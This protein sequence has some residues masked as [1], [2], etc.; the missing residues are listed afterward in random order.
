MSDFTFLN[1]SDIALVLFDQSVDGEPMIASLG[2]GTEFR[3]DVP[4]SVTGTV[5]TCSPT[6][7]PCKLHEVPGD[8][9]CDKGGTKICGGGHCDYSKGF[10]FAKKTISYFISFVK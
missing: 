7:V 4:D 2:I 1:S 6:T 3:I 5:N 8:V 9:R 10:K